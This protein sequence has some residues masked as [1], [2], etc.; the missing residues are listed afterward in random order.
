LLLPAVV[1]AMALTALP[2]GAADHID[3][4]LTKTDGRT[5]ITDVYA[6][7]SPENPANTVLIMNVNPLAGMLSGTTFDP[8]GNYVLNV[9]NNGD[10]KSDLAV[11]VSFGNPDAIGQQKVKVKVDHATVGMGT[12]GETIDLRRGGKAWTG[13]A[14]D[15]FFFDLQAF[16]DLKTMLGGGGPGTGRTFCD[17]NATDFFKGTNVSSIVV[18][19]P[20]ASLTAKGNPMIG[21]FG[22][23][24][25]GPTLKDQMGR[26]AINTVFVGDD[27]K[28]E[29]NATLP[30]KM[31]AAFG[32]LFVDDLVMLSGLDGSGYTPQ[33]AQTIANVLLPDI[34]T[35]DTSSSAGFLNGRQPSN[36]VIDAELALVTGGSGG[37][38]PVL[39][40]DCVNANDH[41]LPSSFPYLA[42]KN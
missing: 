23:T 28:D 27:R 35:V 15:P 17:A 9:D 26:P 37:G 3:S 7:K 13:L 33:Q 16:R 19:V 11:E 31:R 36:D 29:F 38:S 30:D 5:D 4:P 6:F 39:S 41:A 34:L 2:A 25:S 40:T 18:E 8:R 10:A 1:A 21:V 22:T 12:T 20:S 42:A 32:Q 24:F 14:D